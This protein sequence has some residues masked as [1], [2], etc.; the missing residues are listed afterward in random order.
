MK[1]EPDVASPRWPSRHE[2]RARRAPSVPPVD[3]EFQPRRF[4]H[5][6]GGSEPPRRRPNFNR[7]AVEVLRAASRI[8][9]LETAIL[10]LVSLACAWPMA[11][12]IHEVYLI[13]K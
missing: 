9:R 11:V 1:H 4:G 5:S 6:F 10:G 12:M 3:C 7:L 8:F 13:L 2:P